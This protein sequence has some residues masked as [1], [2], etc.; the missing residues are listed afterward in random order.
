MWKNALKALFNI[1]IQK[2]ME[3]HCSKGPQDNP[4]KATY[5]F[6]LNVTELKRL[7]TRISWE[8]HVSAEKNA[9]KDMQCQDFI[10]SWKTRKP[11]TG[12]EENKMDAWSQ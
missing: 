6:L 9:H 7:H 3:S 8:Q 11:Q 4:E 5:L 1:R 2:A 10:T 12:N